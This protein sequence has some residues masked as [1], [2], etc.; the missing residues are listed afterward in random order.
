VLSDVKAITA[1]VKK[2]S[3][4]TLVVGEWIIKSALVWV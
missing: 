3:P 2:A 1:A 4:E